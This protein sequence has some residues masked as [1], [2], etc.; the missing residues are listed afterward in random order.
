MSVTGFVICPRCSARMVLRTVRKAGSARYGQQFWGCSRFPNCSG[1]RGYDSAKKSY[2]ST[3][4]TMA[5]T[6][7]PGKQLSMAGV[8][9]RAAMANVMAFAADASYYN[10]KPAAACTA[11]Q[12]EP[13]MK[14]VYIHTRTFAELHKRRE[15]S[16]KK[17]RES[18]QQFAE[19]MRG[20][21]MAAVQ[22]NAGSSAWPVMVKA[23]YRTLATGGGLKKVLLVRSPRTAKWIVVPVS[24]LAP[25][26]QWLREHAKN[27]PD[28]PVMLWTEEL[29]MLNRAREEVL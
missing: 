14:D 13:Y 22:C 18:M 5:T 2:Y 4:T 17:L 10:Y 8:I 24:K 23:D 27:Y 1:T 28:R 26:Y 21:G 29:N 7:N 25:T 11:P 9:G 20:I 15:E 3:A 19:A 6:T 12:A 16:R